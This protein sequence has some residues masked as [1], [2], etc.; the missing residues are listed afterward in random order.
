M[1]SFLIALQFLTPIPLPWIKK[2]DDEALGKSMAW[3]PLVG[4]F[5]GLVLCAVYL[6]AD[7][8]VPRVVVSALLLGAMAII[9]GGLHLDGLA[10]TIDGLNGGRGKA[11]IIK[12]MHDERVGAMGVIGIV[13][14]LLVKF[15]ALSSLSS[16]NIVGALI[17]MSVLSRWAMVASCY[18]FSAAGSTSSLGRRFIENTGKKEFIIATILM[19]A[20][21]FIFSGLIGLACLIAVLLVIVTFNFYVVQRIGGLTGDTLGALGE[22]VEIVTL[23]GILALG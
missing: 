17:T 22:I 18:K 14:A 10:D 16:W 21:L 7:L 12:I 6:T 1:K 20:V 15:A 3:F 2:V 19:L 8:F 23:L 4:I 13:I 11:S 9:S 5:I